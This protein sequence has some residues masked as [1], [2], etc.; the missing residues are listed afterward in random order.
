MVGGWYAF[1]DAYGDNGAPPGTCQTGGFMPSQCSSILFPST[2][3]GVVVGAFPP[4]GPDGG[5]TG[6][7]CLSGTA[8]QNPKS[9]N[10]GD[11]YGIGIGLDFANAGAGRMAYDAPA[12]GIVG[13]TFTVT[14]VPVVLGTADLVVQLSTPTTASAPRNVDVN[15]DG[16]Y[17]LLFS[18][19]TMPRICA[20]GACG[21]APLD[22]NNLTS[23]RFL[24]ASQPDTSVEVNDLC[25]RGL[26]AIVS[27]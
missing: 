20:S 1:G 5:D 18:D 4:G 24:V 14:G 19:L 2:D 21:P 22:T 7:M 15:S 8:A 23:I 17:T 25:V 16:T 26:A 9:P 3:A 6:A 12:H 10:G 11:V 27:E 13:F